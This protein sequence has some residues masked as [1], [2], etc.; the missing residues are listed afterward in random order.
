MLALLLAFAPAPEPASAPMEKLETAIPHGIML[1]EKDKHAEL[2]QLFV[3]P[4]E[5]KK[6]LGMT[7]IDDFAKEFAKDKAKLLLGV[8]K[9]IKGQKPALEDDGKKAVYSLKEE[10]NG[11]KTLTFVKHGKTWHIKN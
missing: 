1:L 2:L 11:K 10:V 3:E 4:E 9:E 6:I 7:K 8:L 5:L